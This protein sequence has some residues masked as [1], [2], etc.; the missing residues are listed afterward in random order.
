[1]VE[2]LDL[3]GGPCRVYGPA[4]GGTETA[5]MLCTNQAPLDRDHDSLSDECLIAAVRQGSTADYELLYLR[6]RDAAFHTAQRFAS[7]PAHVEDVISEAF[8]RILAALRAGRGPDTSFRTYLARTVRNVAL[9]SFKKDRRLEF[10]D[11]IEAH[12]PGVPFVD[13][14]EAALEQNLVGNAFSALPERWQVVL[15]H[16]AVLKQQPH[17]VAEMM[18]VNINTVTSLAYRAREGLR[19]AYFS[20]PPRHAAEAP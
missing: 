18:G 5:R 2:F 16:T 8:A 11:D 4:Q 13:T 19:R 15:W 1:M 3:F 17:V 20:K 6:H 12:G 9:D 14:V 10:T 7:S